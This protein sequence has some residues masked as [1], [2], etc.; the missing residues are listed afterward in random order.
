MDVCRTTF[1]FHGLPDFV[2]LFK[3]VSCVFSVHPCFSL[4]RRSLF[5]SLSFLSRAMK[6]KASKSPNLST[7]GNPP[8]RD[9]MFV[10]PD[11]EKITIKSAPNQSSARQLHQ[12]FVKEKKNTIREKK[13]LHKEEH[14]YSVINFENNSGLLILILPP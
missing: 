3:N 5:H 1:L 4:F 2:F 10:A 13:K 8:T 11:F 7:P 14:S 9:E 6:R 12:P